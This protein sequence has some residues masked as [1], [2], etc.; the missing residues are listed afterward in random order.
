[1][2]KLSAENL[3]LKH[4]I[5]VISVQLTTFQTSVAA[6]ITAQMANMA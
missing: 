4:Q 6:Q 5:S 1:M 2:L 3:G